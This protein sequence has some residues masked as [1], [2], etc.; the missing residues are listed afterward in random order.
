MLG[1]PSLG[2]L[3]VLI[4]AVLLV[5]Y[6]FKLY[7]RRE[8]V[9]QAGLRKGSRAPARMDTVEC[10]RCGTYVPAGVRPDCDRADCPFA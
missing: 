8:S 10:K 3:L 7:N 9:R 1:L 5:W 2:K 6:G 4:A